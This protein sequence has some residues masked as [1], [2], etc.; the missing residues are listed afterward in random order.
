[1]L[2]ALVIHPATLSKQTLNSNEQCMNQ[3]GDNENGSGGGNGS[4]N[5][6]SVGIETNSS[7]TINDLIFEYIR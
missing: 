1:L 2:F 5:G 6:S 7:V 3:L 4:G